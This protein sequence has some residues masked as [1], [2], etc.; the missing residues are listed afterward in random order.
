MKRRIK[1]N[2]DVVKERKKE[3]R[4]EVKRRRRPAMQEEDSYGRVRTFPYLH[5]EMKTYELEE[6]NKM[7]HKKGKKK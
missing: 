7:K 3:K 5:K 2:G 6:K 4:T 1:Y